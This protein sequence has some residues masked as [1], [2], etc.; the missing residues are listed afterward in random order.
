MGLEMMSTRVR[1]MAAGSSSGTTL[2]VNLMLTP[3]GRRVRTLY[4]WTHNESLSLNVKSWK[5]GTPDQ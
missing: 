2:A 1:M 5:N 3:A 4:L